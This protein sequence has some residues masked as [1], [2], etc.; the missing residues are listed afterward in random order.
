M[1]TNACT[2]CG[3]SRVF[4]SGCLSCCRDCGFPCS[5]A[6][7]AEAF[8]D[9]EADDPDGSV[10]DEEYLEARRIEEDCDR[11]VIAYT[12]GGVEPARRRR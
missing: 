3:G 9:E 11:E 12:D 4:P 2:S 1:A 5:F 10:I 7:N 6:L 8:H